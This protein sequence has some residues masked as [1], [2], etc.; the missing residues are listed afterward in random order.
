ME[1]TVEN[2]S[3]HVHY[4]GATKAVLVQKIQIPAGASLADNLGG[5][6]RQKRTRGSIDS[7]ARTTRIERKGER[8]SLFHVRD[9][10]GSQCRLRLIRLP[11][12]S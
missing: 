12:H 9:G 2:D 7:T 1:I 4:A 10:T 8:A 3:K 5:G 11:D 6:G